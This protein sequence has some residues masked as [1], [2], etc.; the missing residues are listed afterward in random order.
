MITDDFANGNA[1]KGLIDIVK[2]AGAMFRD[3]ARD[4]KGL[5]GGGDE[6]RKQGY[7]VESLTS[8]EMETENFFRR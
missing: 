2:Q 8:R 7:R 5:S 3:A 6:L 4:R 1:L